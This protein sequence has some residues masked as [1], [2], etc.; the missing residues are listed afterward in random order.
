ML[1]ECVLCALSVRLC[2]QT[3]LSSNVCVLSSNVC[4]TED[5][6]LYLELKVKVLLVARATN[7]NETNLS[8][9]FICSRVRQCMYIHIWHV[10]RVP[11]QM[12]QSARL[13]KMN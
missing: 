13:V 10:F 3:L 12:R 8:F 4:G 7:S 11:S 5:I 6:Y 9:N 2:T 1:H